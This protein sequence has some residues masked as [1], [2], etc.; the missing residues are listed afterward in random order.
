MT[1]DINF[2]GLTL[3]NLTGQDGWALGAGTVNVVDT[4]AANGSQSIELSAVSSNWRKRSIT[5][6]T[7]DNS[8]MYISARATSMSV[9]GALVLYLWG[10]GDGGDR[11]MDFEIST[12]AAGEWYLRDESGTR[13]LQGSGL[14][15]DTWYRFGLEFDFSNN[16]VRANI[17][18]G[19]MG[20][21]VSMTNGR[22]QVNYIWLQAGAVTAANTWYVDEI[23]GTESFTPPVNNWTAEDSFNSYTA[24]ASIAGADGGRGWGA[25]NWAANNGSPTFENGPD[26]MTGVVLR[27]SGSTQDQAQREFDAVT[28]GEFEFEF[29]VTNIN[30]STQSG[31]YFYQGA[32]N[33]LIFRIS[34]SSGSA[35][36]VYNND[37]GVYESVGTIA[38]NETYTVRVKFGNSV[39]ANKFQV[40]FNGGAYGAEK[41]FNGT[42]SGGIDKFFVTAGGSDMSQMYVNNI[43]SIN[44]NPGTENLKEYWALDEASGNRVGVHNSLSLSEGNG[45]IASAAGITDNAVDFERDS[46]QYLSIASDPLLDIKGSRTY[47][48]AI[49]SETISTGKQFYFGRKSN[50]T[51]NQRGFLTGY[52]SNAG[53]ETWQFLN[54]DNGS[55]Y[56]DVVEVDVSGDPLVVGTAYVIMVVYHAPSSTYYVYKDGVLWAS[57]SVTGTL[58]ST[59]VNTADFFINNNDANGAWDGEVEDFM[60]FDVALDA[61]NADWFN[62]SG[63][64]RRYAD[65]TGGGG[66]ANQIGSILGITNA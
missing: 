4:Q 32:T 21:W 14:A 3:G 15:A 51:G 54:S 18:G 17:D 24:G 19:A 55:S 63:A 56:G 5:A 13:H 16:R 26:R 37:T 27:C 36:E 61:D 38:A 7:A 25:N 11:V 30:T 28:A 1:D 22:T 60:V 23:S 65:F 44:A 49:N 34:V 41:A 8:I 40:S 33:F 50:S 62:N 2:E 64:F 39:T 48:F 6:I 9:T 59:F 57:G 43:R 10:N 52:N 45:P 66:L 31:F 46:N 58:K 35:L 53:N 42:M 12:N 29:E 20:S 47:V